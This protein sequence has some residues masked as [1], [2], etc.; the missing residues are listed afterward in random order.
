MA[1][2]ALPPEPADL[3]QKVRAWVYRIATAGLL[4]AGIYEVSTDLWTELAATVPGFV[5]S[6]L[7]A[8]NTP[9]RIRT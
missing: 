8:I 3:S 2:A 5:T 9:T 1:T 4:V 6:A 7:A